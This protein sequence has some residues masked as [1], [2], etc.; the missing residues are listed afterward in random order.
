MASGGG[1]ATATTARFGSARC[2][3]AAADVPWLAPRHWSGVR[4]GLAGALVALAQAAPGAEPPA[5]FVGAAPER[6]VPERVKLGVVGRQPAREAV[7]RRVAQ[8]DLETLAAARE[9]AAR[10]GPAT[11]RLNLFEDAEFEWMPE[12]AAA[13]ASGYSLSGPLAGV[14]WGTATLVANGGMVVGSAWTPAAEYRIRT[15]GRSQIV[16]RIDSAHGPVCDGAL[17]PGA[18]VPDRTTAPAASAGVAADDGSEID[19]LVAYTRQARRW[20]GGHRAVLADIDHDV[21]W[22]NEALAVSGAGFRVR[23]V[24]TVAL[25]YDEARD[26]DVGMQSVE[27]V[28]R[29][30]DRHAADVVIFKRTRGGNASWLSSLADPERRAET[31][32]TAFVPVGRQATFAHELGHVMGLNHH[33]GDYNGNDPF[34]YSHGYILP[35]LRRDGN[36]A[37]STIMAYKSLPRFS[38]PRQRFLG[39]PLGVHGDEP[40]WRVDGPADAVRSLNETRRFVAGYRQSAA[41]CRYRLSAPAEVPAAGGRYT[42]R[43]AADPGCAWAARSADGVTT[44]A[45]GA[46]GIGDGAVEYRVPANDGWEREVALAVAGRMHV[47]TQPGTRQLKPACE[48]SAAVR[49]TLEAEVGRACGDITAAD[50]RGI[51]ALT[52]SDVRPGDLDGLANLA[53]LNLWLWPPSD[54]ILAAGT[55]DG[56]AGLLLLDISGWNV[57]LEPGLFRGLA[58]LHHLE[59]TS[60]RR[61]DAPALPPLRRGVFDGLPRLRTLRLIDGSRSAIE[62]GL[63]GALPL[64]NELFVGGRLAHLPAGMFRGLANLRRLEV[65]KSEGTSPVTAEAGAFEGLPNLEELELNSLAAVPRGVFA[66]LS[67]L[68]RLWLQRNAFTSLEAGVFDGLRSLNDLHL[69]NTSR[70]RHVPHRHELSTL[71]SGLFAGLPMR[72]LDLTDVGLRELR[73]GT[74]RDTMDIGR[75]GRLYLGHNRLAK[76]A[77]ETFDGMDALYVLDLSG[78]R[79]ASLPVRPFEGLRWLG[80]LDVSH[81]QLA[82]LPPGMFVGA[83][84]RRHGRCGDR[85]SYNC[86]T[87]ALHGNPGAPFRLALEP[88]VASAA[89]QRPVRVAVHVAEG[90]PFELDV[91]LQAE[92]GRLEADAATIAPATDLSDALAVSPAGAG[93]VV[94]QVA[95]VPDVPGANCAE[96]LDAGKPCGLHYTGIRLAAGEP[97]VLN[98]IAD[99]PMFDAPAEI[100]LANV[101]LELDGSDA[102]TF[103]VRSSDPRVASPELAGAA[104]RVA[105]GEPGTAT[106]AVTA[107]AA[108]GRTATR[109]FAVTVP[110]VTSPRFLRG[111]RLGLLVDDGADG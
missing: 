1:S 111:W 31:S 101:F 85:G 29:L 98:G 48:R 76:L 62:P 95:A 7:R 13:T 105:P 40:S 78:N 109:A 10:R 35:G 108:D 17:R 36:R 34:P 11:V 23:L 57:R 4:A 72:M 26:K 15:V 44:V 38:N 84:A 103:A 61:D 60:N 69:D 70:R 55:F 82:A 73:A 93:P 81:N 58:N 88:V 8:L 19:V 63:F 43:V 27:E 104:L 6:A 25:D 66:G 74:F 20:A 37:Y 22:T 67:E 102:A 30:R 53:R 33:R 79:L 71:P 107:T 39:V 92:G 75:I 99:M 45:S 64:L 49:E 3:R 46:S 90:A 21:A 106:V 52:L 5:L 24:A 51:V 42:L 47:A 54:R 97:L 16:E 91:G 100:D 14:E 56:L 68:R 83:S 80:V 65:Y 50:L 86:L 2:R 87:V 9:A 110:G 77:R 96:I 18:A 32:H 59:F 89:W 12:R 41:R 28:P 94:V